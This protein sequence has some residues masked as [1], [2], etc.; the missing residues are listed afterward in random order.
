MVGDDRKE[1]IA[2]VIFI[3]AFISLLA[4]MLTDAK[5]VRIKGPDINNR[6]VRWD[7]YGGQE[8]KE[9]RD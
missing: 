4:L 7:D 3:V 8:A 5:R 2:N 1:T 6:F 9:N